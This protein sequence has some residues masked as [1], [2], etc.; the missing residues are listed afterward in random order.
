MNFQHTEIVSSKDDELLKLQ[1]RERA[2]QSKLE[3]ADISIREHIET[4]NHQKEL[5]EKREAKLGKMRQ[6]LED[7]QRHREEAD[8]RTR[9]AEEQVR[10]MGDDIEGLQKEIRKLKALLAKAAEDT[11]SGRADDQL[12]DQ[13]G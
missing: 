11:R 3:K 5:T 1:K 4:N 8:S 13:M 2:T 12:T 10:W 9:K 6:V 7:I